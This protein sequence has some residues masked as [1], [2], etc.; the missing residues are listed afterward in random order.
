MNVCGIDLSLTNTAV[1]VGSS[2][3][4]VM[5]CFHAGKPAG[6]VHGRTARFEA[7]VDQIV[8]FIEENGPVGL[9]AIEGYSY[10]SVGGQAWDRAEY[11][12]ILNFHLIEMATHIYEVAP[13]MLK[14]FCA[15]K[16]GPGKAMVI[17]A[18]TRDYGVAF[19]T[20]DAYDA[21]GLFRMGLCLAG[22]AEPRTRAQRECIDTVL[23][24][25][26]KAKRSK[27]PEDV[28]SELFPF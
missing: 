25:K 21:F 8:R 19:T 24:L 3:S 26:N 4:H 10:G 28:I 15:G 17:G 20:D 12:G 7:L 1:C 6:S 14:K 27:Q 13:M 18:L 11:R 22:Y 16:A 9:V 5:Q 23:G 2:D